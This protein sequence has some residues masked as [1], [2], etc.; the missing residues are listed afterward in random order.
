M[1]TL[2]RPYD[3]TLTYTAYAKCGKIQM[4]GF[5]KGKVRKYKQI[6]KQLLNSVLVGYE[7]LLR[8]RFVLSDNTNLRLNNSSYPTRTEFNNC[9]IV[10]TTKIFAM[11]RRIFRKLH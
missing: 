7:E 5:F 3:V 10:D 11:L 2:I 8:P 6:I 9:L 1:K 4:A